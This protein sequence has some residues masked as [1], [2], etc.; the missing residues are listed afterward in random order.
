ML[1]LG[2]L[3]SIPGIKRHSPSPRVSPSGRRW[4]AC[5]VTVLEDSSQVALPVDENSEACLPALLGTPGPVRG[6]TQRCPAP[7]VRLMSVSLGR[8]CH[9]S[10]WW[11]ADDP[12]ILLSVYFASLV[13]PAYSVLGFPPQLNFVA[14]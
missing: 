1:P 13:H 10:R 11:K 6:A 2:P 12:Q 3:T 5:L 7:P 8:G 4:A 9:G 14:F